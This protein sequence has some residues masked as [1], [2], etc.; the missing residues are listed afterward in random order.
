MPIHRAAGATFVALAS[1]ALPAAA[2]TRPADAQ[3]QTIVVTG[4]RTDD[5]GL[6]S[7]IPLERVPQSVQLIDEEALEQPE[8]RSIADALAAVPSAQVGTNRAADSPSFAYRIRGFAPDVMRNGMRQRYYEDVDVSALSNVA[9]IEVLKGPFAALYG[10]SAI[11]GIVSIITKQPTDEFAG[12]VAL[13]GGTF[14]QA[15]A[16]I[17]VG[18]PITG[19][20]GFRLTGEIERSG[21]IIDFV[22]LDRN[23]VA[24]TLAWR[25]SASVSAHLVAEYVRRRTTNYPGLPAVGTVTGNGVA[26]ADRATYLGEP[27]FADQE[28]DAPL[29]QAW[30]DIRLGDAW[31]LTPRF[32]YSEFNNL[33]QAVVLGPPVAGQPTRIQRTGRF[34]GENDRFYVAR[35]DLAGRTVTFGIGHELVIGAEY[36]NEKV[37]FRLRAALP[38]GVGAIDALNP[39][40]GCGAPTTGF[41]F[42]SVNKVEGVAVY[43]QDQIA[44]TDR[45]NL[46]AGL[47]HSEFETS[48]DFITD[49]FSTASTANLGNTTWQLGSTFALGSGVSLYGGYNTGFDLEYVLG[50]RRRD[51][52]PFKPETSDQAE[53]GVRLTRETVRASLSVFRI[54]RND[55]AVPDPADPGFQVQEGQFRIAG[56]ELEGEWSPRPGWWLQGGYAYLDGEISQTTNAPLRGARL[57]ETPEH[58]ATLATRVTLGAIE[59]RARANYAGARRLVNGGSLTLPDYVV[60]DLGIGADLGPFRVDAALTNALDQTYYYSNNGSVYSTGREDIVFPGEPRTFSLRVSYSFGGRQA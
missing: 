26:T 46:V 31:T 47:R 51:G 43:A 18:G 60:L 48:S 17:D 3:P 10:E 59:L 29:I 25:P 50:A 6:R 9:R 15:T 56:V 28:S 2:Q 4:T 11:G 55:V 52:T 30:V 12:F 35:V 57:A 45:W 40:Y 44:L 24:L 1:S 23:N 54:R 49:F 39:V 37:P 34:A 19:T 53:I 14:D 36:S 41:G 20:L 21:T 5:F 7:G 38:C 58:N 8:T 13:T 32:Q 16:T 27:S 22:D 33:G 42:L